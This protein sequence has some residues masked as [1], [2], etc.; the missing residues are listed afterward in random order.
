MA[1]MLEPPRAAPAAAAEPRVHQLDVLLEPHLSQV[2]QLEA[3]AFPPCE[4]F[5]GPVLQQQAA[6]RTNGLLLA[7]LG[8]TVA[9]FLL[10]ARSG[11]AALI[12][13]LA[14]HS[15]FRRRGIGSALMRHG[16]AEIEGGARRAGP[17]QIMLHV[18]PSRANAVRLYESFGFRR[19]ELL[20]RYYVDERDAL[21][22]RRDAARR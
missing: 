11:G 16:I 1:A 13:K 5:G 4:R 14:V 6:L 12:T 18:D 20:P 3:D 21:V 22:M 15:A 17:P 2:L 10:F 8:S 9:G 7:E 19:S